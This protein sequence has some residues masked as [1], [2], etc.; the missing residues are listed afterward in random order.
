MDLFLNFTLIYLESVTEPAKL[1]VS[2]WNLG[3][4]IEF[5]LRRM[6]YRNKRVRFP[7]RMEVDPFALLHNQ[8]LKTHMNLILAWQCS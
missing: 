3:K 2:W 6:Q 8:L 4:K 7:N 5:G 1:L